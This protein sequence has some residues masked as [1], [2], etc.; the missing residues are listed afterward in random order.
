MQDIRCEFP[1]KGKA[2]TI[3]C[4]SLS[5]RGKGTRLPSL[6][7]HDHFRVCA[8]MT[9]RIRLVEVESDRDGRTCP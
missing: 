8:L 7:S 9:S 6:S 4:F 2:K 1:S 3:A 5:P